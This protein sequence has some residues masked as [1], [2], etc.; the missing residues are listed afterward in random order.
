MSDWDWANEDPGS[1]PHCGARFDPVRPG[2]SQPSCDCQDYCRLHEPPVRLD[3]RSA[4]KIQGWVC[5]A[6]WPESSDESPARP[7]APKG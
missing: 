5:P 6:C 4:G 2:K 7:S 3:Y 1:C